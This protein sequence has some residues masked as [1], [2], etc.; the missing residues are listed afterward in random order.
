MR[1]GSNANVLMNRQ[2]GANRGLSPDGST[3]DESSTPKAKSMRNQSN[4]SDNINFKSRELETASSITSGFESSALF[5]EAKPLSLTVE[6]MVKA[7]VKSGNSPGDILRK[8]ELGGN[9]RG[10]LTYM[11]QQLASRSSPEI[12]TQG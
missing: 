9:E 7:N 6:A 4:R 11:T 2:A 12:N 5:K 3:I 8:S 10:S 1:I